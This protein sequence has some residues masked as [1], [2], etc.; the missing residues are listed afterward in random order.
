M[1]YFI[2]KELKLKIM[3]RTKQT[4]RKGTDGSAHRTEKAGGPSNS[5]KGSKK[6]TSKSAKEEE[7]MEARHSCF[8]RNMTLPK[9]YRTSD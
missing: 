6:T 9:K 1:K 2:Y 7:K 8:E 4:A 3:A 5:K